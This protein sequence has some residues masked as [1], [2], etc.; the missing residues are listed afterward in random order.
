MVARRA[1]RGSEPFASGAPALP[2]HCALCGRPLVA[3]PSI[4]E[5]HLLPRSQGGRD[6]TPIHRVCHRKIHATL[7]EKELA[8][9][10]ASWDALRGHAEIADFIR[11]VANKPPTFYDRSARPNRRR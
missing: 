4:D 9:G 6:K 10:Y 3:G 5:H 8:R 11:W 2:S 7:S 1:L